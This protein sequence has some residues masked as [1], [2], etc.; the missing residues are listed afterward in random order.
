MR[1]HENKSL[2]RQ[3]IQFTSDQ[4][5]ML[6]IFVEKD[7]WVTYALH[8]IFSNAVG[9]NTIFKGG[10]ALSKCY[11]MIDR[12]SEDIDLVVI[13]R[14]GETDNRLKT[15]IQTISKVVGSVL[16]EVYVEGLTV[17]KGMN[18]KTVHTYNKQFEGNS[19][20]VRDSIVVEATWLGYHEPY[21][22]KNIISFVGEMMLNNKQDKFA[23]ENGLLPFDV[24]VL[25]P[26]RT[27]CEK[28]MSMVRFS[29]GED[30]INDLKKKIRH[31]YDL[32]QLL[33]QKEL[34]E[35]FT[36]TAFDEMLLKV[37]TDD[38]ASFRN[39]NQWLVYH[40]IKTLIFNNLNNIWNELKPIY[41]G[42]F[43][44]LVYKNLPTDEAILETLHR[45]KERLATITWN[46]KI[47][48]FK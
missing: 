21:T 30:P 3:A 1:L 14:E 28:I 47:G 4:I 40:P 44:N 26:T 37:A 16:P 20:Q 33:Q 22:T 46:I 13:R 34:S 7:Y 38:A 5:P 23:H 43:K 18:R 29:Y 41:N 17:K 39:N 35:F 42:D 32:H 2:F 6:P 45:I 27:L 31:A 36:S 10:T 19:G 48:T 15:K 25:E 9:R 12:F 8:T 24:C 11:N